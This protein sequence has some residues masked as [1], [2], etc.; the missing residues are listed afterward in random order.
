MRFMFFFYPALA[1]TLEERKR[2]RPIARHTEPWQKMFDE[3]AELSRMAEDLGF[4]AVTFPEHHLHTEGA[5]MGSLPVLTQYVINQTERIKVGPIGYVLPGWNPLRLALEIAWLDQLTKG[6]TFVGF[7]RGYQARWLNAMAQKV[8]IGAS[9]IST[10]QED[11]DARN[12]NKQPLPSSECTTDRL[13]KAHFALV[14]TTSDIRREMDLLVETANPEWFIWQSDQGYL[15]LDQVKRM[16]QR[17]GKE[18]LP[19]YV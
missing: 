4:E 11:I 3:V 1:A 17:F 15:P 5:E 7:A 18:I 2:M 14:G 6:C 16:L 19:H 13:E 12:P 8:N 10:M 9:A